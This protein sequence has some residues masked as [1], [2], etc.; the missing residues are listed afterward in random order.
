MFNIVFGLN[1][2][3]N[4]PLINTNT[5]TPIIVKLSSNINPHDVSANVFGYPK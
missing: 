4:Q 1:L 3:E 2:I 5:L